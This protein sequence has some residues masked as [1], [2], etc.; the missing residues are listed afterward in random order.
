MTDKEAPKRIWASIHDYMVIGVWGIEVLR[1]EG[2]IAYIRADRYDALL[3]A[4]VSLNYHLLKMRDA[5]IAGSITFDKRTELLADAQLALD[6][7]AAW[8]NGT[9]E[10]ETKLEG[11]PMF[12]VIDE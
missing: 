9:K 3:D 12:E 5:V 10:V 11:L 2:D 6:K 4:A 8:R 1:E 7:L